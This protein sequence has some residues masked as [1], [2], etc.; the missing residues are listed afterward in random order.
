[1]AGGNTRVSAPFRAGVERRRP[2]VEGAIDPL[3]ARCCACWTALEGAMFH[4]LGLFRL[5]QRANK[6]G[7]DIGPEFPVGNA[8]GRFIACRNFSNPDSRSSGR[9]HRQTRR[10]MPSILEG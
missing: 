1:M 6:A 9:H 8:R 5:S 10:T 2:W 7:T 3:A 4:E